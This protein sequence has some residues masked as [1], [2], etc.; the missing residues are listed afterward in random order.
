MAL[1]YQWHPNC[2][3]FIDVYGFDRDR[4]MT[5][6][7]IR[8]FIYDRAD[9]VYIEER[10]GECIN[11]QCIL[12]EEQPL[13]Y[14]QYLLDMGFQIINWFRNIN[15][16]NM[17]TVYHFSVD[18]NTRNKQ[19]LRSQSEAEADPDRYVLTQDNI[20]KHIYD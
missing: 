2:C 15:S 6:D 4:N 1:S 13:Y 20:R 12:T 11:V 10:E 18:P 17:C 7:Y 9:L 8:E 3:G 5:Y 16:G 14:H 19:N